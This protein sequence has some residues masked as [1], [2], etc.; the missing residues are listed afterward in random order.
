MGLE[1]SK[2]DADLE[3]V[4]AK[5]KHASWLK[6]EVLYYP[7]SRM[8][9]KFILLGGHNTGKSA[10]L[11]R[12]A[13]NTFT[14]TEWHHGD[15]SS[16][17]AVDFKFMQVAL[18]ESDICPDFTIACQIYDLP[19]SRKLLERT[20]GSLFRGVHGYLV[21]FD[22]AR[23]E[24]L[25]ESV[26]WAQQHREH[27]VFSFRDDLTPCPMLLVGLKLDLNWRLHYEPWPFLRL[28]LSLGMP[29]PEEG[30]G[31]SP[32]FVLPREIASHIAL[33]LY[34]SSL[35]DHLPP[36]ARASYSEHY[37]AGQPGPSYPTRAECEAAA[38]RLKA[39]LL[40][41]SA[42]FS[43]QVPFLFESIAHNVVSE[44][45]HDELLPYPISRASQQAD[46]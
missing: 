30:A 45:D 25:E 4:K 11:E 20:K 36:S 9:L 6:E 17:L 33:L 37:V 13:K 18:P 39:P 35:A 29:T 26:Q 23:R 44:F 38:D 10:L 3:Q 32:A 24:S 16:H 31:P 7:L 12:F 27:M 43:F 5:K 1:A 14:D 2:S 15:E 19:G 34:Q 8:R 40:F 46:D 21:C 28:A 22:C 41:S 42:R